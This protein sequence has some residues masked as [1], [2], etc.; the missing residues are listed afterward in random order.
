[1]TSH[2][3][4]FTIFK[5]RRFVWPVWIYIRSQ[6]L[7]ATS[8]VTST[9]SSRLVVVYQFGQANVS[10]VL[11]WIALF[12]RL[13]VVG[14]LLPPWLRF[15]RHKTDGNDGHQSDY[16][17]GGVGW[18]PT[19]HPNYHEWKATETT[20]RWRIARVRKGEREREK[21]TNERTGEDGKVS[22]LLRVADSALWA[23]KSGIDHA[24]FVMGSPGNR[25]NRV[26]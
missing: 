9:P 19:H 2:R 24:S 11:D 22:V 3:S 17:A 14:L 13:V 1:M 20:T 5:T 12:C 15:S 8:L 18:L 26:G 21:R 25:S 7:L 16:S 4:T 10:L 23:G 6:Q